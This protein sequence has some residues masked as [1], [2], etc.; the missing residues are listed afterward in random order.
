M[1]QRGL[2]LARVLHQFRIPGRLVWAGLVAL[3][4]QLRTFYPPRDLDALGSVALRDGA[5]SIAHWLAFL[6][7][8]T[9]AGFWLLRKLDLPDLSEL[10][11]MVFAGALGLGQMAYLA[12]GLGLSGLLYPAVLD[13][14]TVAIAFLTG[15]DLRQF[16]G[17]LSSLARGLR[18]WLKS[19]SP[20]RPASAAVMSLI[21]LFALI[22]TL[23]PAWDYDGLMY[24]LPGPTDF[25]ANHRILPN[26]DNWYVNGPFTVEM[27]FTYGLAHGDVAFAK[28]I[29][30]ALGWLYVTSAAAVA[31]RWLGGAAGGVSAA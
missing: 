30:Y 19:G 2:P 9:S 13:A 18:A 6:L 1:E 21:A 16:T 17:L 25:L 3:V 5:L 22:H 10:E 24:H 28:L 15:A 26:L 12:L 23:G 11:T 14:L 29:H 20:L 27:L 31:R 8:A 4:L 7:V